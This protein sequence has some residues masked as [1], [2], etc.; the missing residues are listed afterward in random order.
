MTSA[1]LV[2]AL[3]EDR[4]KMH[5]QMLSSVSHDLK[6]P[7]ASMIGSLEI[8]QRMKHTLTDAKKDM[9]IT[10]A[11]EEARRLDN[12]ITNI[13][14]MAKLESGHIR[15]NRENT[16]MHVLIQ[17]CLK[18][19]SDRLA[20]T[21]V[22]LATPATRR[23]LSMDAGLISRLLG[24][25][26]DNAIKY[27]PREGK[28]IEI[29]LDINGSIRLSVHDNG[30]GI[31]ESRQEEIFNKYTRLTKQDSQAAGTGL[32]LAISRTIARLHGGDITVRNH[33]Q[34]GAVFTLEIPISVA[35]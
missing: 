33:E 29:T 21:E 27:G 8:Y 5:R 10:T 23:E 22:K 11:L 2:Q 15:L 24:Q 16:D 7:L 12:F 13:L 30:P 17:Q 26:I 28:Q 9:L 34:G 18:R 35:Q 3:Q 32:G 1:E 19:M 6:T 4:E 14:D 31:P 25:L 20:G